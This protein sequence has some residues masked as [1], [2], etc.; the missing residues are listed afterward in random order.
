MEKPKKKKEP[1]PRNPLVE[2]AKEVIKFENYK[3]LDF[4]STDV[5][6]ISKFNA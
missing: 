3:S 4:L 1:R 6:Y 2:E 5:R